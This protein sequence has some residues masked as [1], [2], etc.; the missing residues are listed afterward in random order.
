M[1]EGSWP[2]VGLGGAH[3]KLIERC[4]SD[5]TENTPELSE[6]IEKMLTPQGGFMVEFVI[7]NSA[8]DTPE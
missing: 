4:H 1:A 8:N 6:C 5:E 3:L 7:E 2:G